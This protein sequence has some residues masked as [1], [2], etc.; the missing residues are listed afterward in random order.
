[1]RVFERQNDCVITFHL[2][3]S[4]ML[5]R[6]DP[7]PFLAQRGG[8]AR[9]LERY[10]AVRAAYSS[11]Y[12]MSVS[13]R[14]IEILGRALVAHTFVTTSL[15]VVFSPEFAINLYRNRS[16]GS[17]SDVTSGLTATGREKV[18]GGRSRLL[19]A[20]FTRKTGAKNSRI[21]SG[22]CLYRAE[23]KS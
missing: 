14:A 17:F 22:S 11:L 9:L 18:R 2:N 15:G 4:L 12:S 20:F 19:M 3:K 7:L 23:S 8:Y 16:T 6:P 1:M 21:N 13:C 5:D 10:D